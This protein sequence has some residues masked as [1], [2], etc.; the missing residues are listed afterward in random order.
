L[1]LYTL[2][3]VILFALY[4]SIVYQQEHLRIIYSFA[5]YIPIYIDLGLDYTKIRKYLCRSSNNNNTKW[6]Q[7]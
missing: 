3:L 5:K 2:N 6:I 4:Q 1:K 7:F